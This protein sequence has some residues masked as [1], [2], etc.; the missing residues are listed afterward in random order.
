[1]TQGKAFHNLTKEGSRTE[2]GKQIFQNGAKKDKQRN[3]QANKERRGR[4]NGPDFIERETVKKKK[5]NKKRN[6]RQA[7][8]GKS[9]FTRG[10]KGKEKKDHYQPDPRTGKKGRKHPLPFSQACD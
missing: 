10:V 7:K 1:V 5:E 3:E 4:M 8:I 9:A 6:R 2:G